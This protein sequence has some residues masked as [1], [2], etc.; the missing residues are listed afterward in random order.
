[1]QMAMLGAVIYGILT[2]FQL[3]TLPVEFDAS[4]RAKQRL[5]ALT[6]LGEREMEGVN[7][8][9]DAA[10]WTYVAAFISSLGWLLYFLAASRD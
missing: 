6:I 8:T 1:P 9:L 3:V 2:V 7:D 10:A 5:V 4:R